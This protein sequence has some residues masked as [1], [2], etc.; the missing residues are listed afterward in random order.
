MNLRFYIILFIFSILVFTKPVAGQKLESRLVFTDPTAAQSYLNIEGAQVFSTFKFSSKN[1]TD[2]QAVSTSQDYS[3]ITGN[4][5]SLVYQYINPKGI[6]GLI[7]IGMRQAGS[8]LV[9][10][11][12]DYIWNMQYADMRAGMGYQVNK[13]RIKPFGSLAPYYSYLMDAK[14][15]LGLL[16]YDMKTNKAVK[17]YD[18]GLF[19]SLGFKALISKQISIFSE[20]NYILGLKNIE[21]ATSQSLY[22][23]GFSIRLGLSLNITKS[24]NSNEVY[25]Q[26][27]TER[28]ADITL[29]PANANKDPLL[30]I[31]P[32]HNPVSERNV[33]T[34]KEVSE[35]S[36]SLTNA[37]EKPLSNPTAPADT[38]SPISSIAA[39]NETNESFPLDTSSFNIEETPEITHVEISSSLISS[40]VKSKP[41]NSN[42]SDATKKAGSQQSA[43]QQTTDPNPIPNN[44]IFKIQITA[45]K[46]PL[47]ETSAALKNLSGKIEMEKRKDG[48]IR[49]Y[50][51]SFKKYEQARLELN[52]L[53]SN[54]GAV[55]G[56]IV[57][58][59]NGKQLTLSEAK[60]LSK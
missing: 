32:L 16:K 28:F 25:P 30:K 9:Y 48:F 59:N 13:W 56:F 17:N 7:G 46:K 27:T 36:N 20:Y 45:V 31:T 1:S 26:D 15:S 54:G 37:K 23:R 41:S 6:Y 10:K 43:S 33:D 2:A 52:D 39:T 47:R 51:G 18:L 60:K 3:R 40:F 8:E 34:V 12:V 57:A 29:P 42:G 4:A 58:F 38:T 19:F 14:Q 50:I 21:T 5:F 49:Y 22:N 24:L 53:K 44:I 35:N 55:N 11:N